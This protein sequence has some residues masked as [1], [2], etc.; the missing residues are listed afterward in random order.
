[1]KSSRKSI[2]NSTWMYVLVG[3]LLVV[4]AILF[5]YVAKP[6]ELFSEQ[7][8]LEYFYME[9]CPHCKDFGP[10]W[11]EAVNK[12]NADPSTKG[13]IVMKKYNIND[14][15]DGAKR[16]AKYNIKSAPTVYYVY[17]PAPE[18]HYE[19]DGPRTAD[20]ILAFV[21]AKLSPAASS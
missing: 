3:A 16:A 18:D 14:D 12:V 6:M 1:M 9:T 4:S 13:K 21:K 8:S 2:W 11:D 10:I 7:P 19:Y 20:A 17:G 15:T 5:F